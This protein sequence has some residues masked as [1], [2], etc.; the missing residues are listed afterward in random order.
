MS[1]VVPGHQFDV[2]PNDLPNTVDGSV[3]HESHT[4]FMQNLDRK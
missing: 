3:M 2:R 4:V 1:C